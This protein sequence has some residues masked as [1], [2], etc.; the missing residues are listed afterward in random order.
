MTKSSKV[1]RIFLCK[2]CHG[3]LELKEHWAGLIKRIDKYCPECARES[4]K[5]GW[6]SEG[7]YVSGGR[8]TCPC[9]G[10][11]VRV[12]D[13]EKDDL[14]CP[15]CSCALRHYM[16]EIMRRSTAVAEVKAEDIDAAK[17]DPWIIV[18]HPARTFNNRTRVSPGAGRK[19]FL[20]TGM[21][22]KELPNTPCPIS[23]D[24]DVDGRIVFVLDCIAHQFS[25]GTANPPTVVSEKEHLS[26]RVLYSMLLT[27][28]ITDA[29]RFIKWA[30]YQDSTLS[31][32]VEGKKG[33]PNLSE[34]LF[35]IFND[36]G[37]RSDALRRAV[38]RGARIASM[39]LDKHLVLEEI[40]GAM[41]ERLAEFGMK[42]D[43]CSWNSFKVE[44]KSSTDTLLARASGQVE[45]HTNP[46]RVHE[47]GDENLYSFLVLGGHG[48][49]TL[50]DREKLLTFAE[51]Q[52]W[53]DPSNPDDNEARATIGQ[54]IGQQLNA[55]FQQ[56]LQSMINDT[57]AHIHDIS[58]YLAYMQN[59]AVQYV[60]E[61]STYLSSRGLRVSDLTVQVMENR[62]S[63]ALSA[64]TDVNETISVKTIEQEMKRFNDRLTIDNAGDDSSVRIRLAGIS[65]TEEQEMYRIQKQVKDTHLQDQLDEMERQMEIS[66]KKQQLE[67]ERLQMGA[68]YKMTD[69]RLQGE[70]AQQAAQIQEEREDHETERK[71]AREIQG[72]DHAYATWLKQRRLEQEKIS[73][74][75][76]DEDARQQ[77]KI[78]MTHRENQA[79]R[80]ER[81]ADEDLK[82]AIHQVARGI[83]ESNL[84]WQ[85]KL[86]AYAHL[87]KMTEANDTLELDERRERSRVNL[88]TLSEQAKLQISRETAE[89]L[90]MRERYQEE[91]Q[92]RIRKA[93]FAREMERRRVETAD[94]IQ[95]LQ[96]EMDKKREEQEWE[97]KTQQLQ[98]EIARLQIQLGHDETMAEQD[99]NKTRMQYE[100]QTAQVQAVHNYKIE[101]EAGAQVLAML[102]ERLQ[103]CKTDKER[104]EALAAEAK[105]QREEMEERHH[106]EQADLMAKNSERIEHLYETM[107]SL[108]KQRE[109]LRAKNEWA[110]HEGRVM[111]DIANATK[112]DAARIDA[113][114]DYI[115]KIEEEIQKMRQRMRPPK[116]ENHNP[117]SSASASTPASSSAVPDGMKKCPHCGALLDKYRNYCPSC[118][119][120]L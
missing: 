116:T 20:V 47:S 54:E 76:D 62:M 102:R 59:Q 29:V 90:E 48:Q 80:D 58:Q 74:L 63:A 82:A 100:A 53:N 108:E 17:D 67:L 36:E 73:A 103:E 4:K 115:K 3:E 41:D 96:M 27:V 118:G 8:F 79:A 93:D 61:S 113:M 97:F 38:E 11:I 33:L 19:A 51:G 13:Y 65:G 112:N 7:E 16:G 32:V 21:E 86:D 1:E 66:R 18:S 2:T 57:K 44:G 22:W 12:E 91:R 89:Q 109:E 83:E 106:K 107:L 88:F 35:G 110:Y 114:F 68:Q 70:V 98:F 85:K 28:K 119:K 39:E 81:L 94:Q 40:R 23:G 84:D 10:E 69:T 55:V 101:A 99:V 24:D 46:I 120:F 64:R 9:C 34:L 78:G 52:R 25:L 31:D 5:G 87:Q 45:W 111:V 105:R 15:K 77:H 75:M 56:L 117:S 95:L 37:C 104:Q 60:N 92:E 6:K 43:T 49:V 30:H 71:Q 42:I 26:A 14:R 72:L 50:V